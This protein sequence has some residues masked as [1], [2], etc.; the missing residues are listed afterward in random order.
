MASEYQSNR[1]TADEHKTPKDS[2]RLP[3]PLPKSGPPVLNDGPEPVRS[4]HT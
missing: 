2:P 3:Q 4:T 1:Q